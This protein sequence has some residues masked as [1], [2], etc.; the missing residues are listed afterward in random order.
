M[1]NSADSMARKIEMLPINDVNR[2]MAQ[3][4]YLA[5]EATVAR[6]VRAVAWLCA[7]MQQRALSLR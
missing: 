7:V 5:A 6:I 3:A 2:N 1:F 4:N